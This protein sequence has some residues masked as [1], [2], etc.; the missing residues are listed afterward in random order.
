MARW[1][2]IRSRR[3][4][5]KLGTRPCLGPNHARR[6]AHALP[7]RGR[8]M[9]CLLFPVHDT[10][11]G[12]T[13]CLPPGPSPV[14]SLALPPVP[15]RIEIHT[16]PYP[17]VPHHEWSMTVL[18]GSSWTRWRSVCTR[19]T[20]PNRRA[21]AAA[22]SR[23]PSP[24][25]SSPASGTRTTGRR[26]AGWRRRTGPRRPSC[27]PTATS[28]PTP[29]PGRRRPPGA[30][31][32]RRRPRAPRPRGTAGGTSPPRGRWTP[33][34]AWTT[35]GWQGTSSSTT[36]ATTA[37]ASRRRPRSARSGP[38]RPHRDH[39]ILLDW[40]VHDDEMNFFGLFVGA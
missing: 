5:C 31:R 30:P 21:E 23:S 22:S 10:A 4:P 37:S 28:P 8:S 15:P 17:T 32:P 29:A 16:L 1:I 11:H 19:T 18:A 34:S 24:C 33:G 39:A 35:P 26:A 14:R 20:R 13:A 3:R 7:G 38:P 25:T 27:R 9:P 12:S 2:W 40:F 6:L 36:T